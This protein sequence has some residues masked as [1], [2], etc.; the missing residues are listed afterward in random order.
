M[1]SNCAD[2]K[3]KNLVEKNIGPPHNMPRYGQMWGHL[4]LPGGVVPVCR[5]LIDPCWSRGGAV[6][7]SLV[8]QDSSLR[9]GHED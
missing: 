1:I 2:Q 8:R 4:S 7:V 3:P 6:R 5:P 9:P